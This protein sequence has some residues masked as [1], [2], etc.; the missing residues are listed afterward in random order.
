M[1]RG[2]YFGFLLTSSQ[3]TA[4][5]FGFVK[6]SYRNHQTQTH[7]VPKRDLTIQKAIMMEH[8]GNSNTAAARG[9]WASTSALNISFLFLALVWKFMNRHG[10]VLNMLVG[11]NLNQ[12]LWQCSYKLLCINLLSVKVR[13]FPL[14]DWV[15]FLFLI[16]AIF[17]SFPMGHAQLIKKKCTS[18]HQRH[19][20]KSVI[21]SFSTKIKW[22]SYQI[23]SHTHSS[24]CN[25]FLQ[26][27]LIA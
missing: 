8:S 1:K 6:Q 14:K 3:L 4:V 26:F 18:E 21:W 11:L 13:T 2:C 15:L 12:C 9:D 22:K 25:L 16:Q 24:K 7:I 19:L 23:K 5:S 27:F 17:H 10:G 20:N